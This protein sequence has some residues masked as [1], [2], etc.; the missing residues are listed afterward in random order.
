MLV[1][2]RDSGRI[3]HRVVSDLPSF[4]EP[5]DL[6]VM[7]DA[8]VIPARLY[9]EDAA[10][11]MLLLEEL[12]GCVWRALVKPGRK[13]RLDATVRV[14]GQTG[15]VIAIEEDGTRHIQFEGP[16]DL[17]RF[18]ELPLPPY[19]ERRPDEVDRERYQTVFAAK[20]GAIAA[21]TAGLHFTPE[22]LAQID[23]ACVTLYVGV[24]TFRPV[25]SEH[26]EGHIMHS[27]RCEV[28]AAAAARMNAAKRILAIG[29]TT[30]RVLES[31][32]RPFIET[33]GSTQIFIHPPYQFRA[34]DRLLT[35]FH[36][37]K[38]TLLMLVSAMAGREAILAAYAQAVSERYRF[39]SY[40]DCM[41]IL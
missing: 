23:S 5:G 28:T 4:M 9:S 20:P 13:M 25:Q 34:V 14:A 29:T 41:L 7:N 37:P 1:L 35:N 19:F 17:N 12:P 8:Q 33:Q 10:V 18:G 11:E 32:G 16:V 38:S 21:P 40:G 3:E 30:V 15:R 36:L 2:H 27:E 6:A 39:F 31:M 24:G 22:L 26:L